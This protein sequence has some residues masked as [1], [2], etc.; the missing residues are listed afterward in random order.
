MVK[1][2]AGRDLLGMGVGSKEPCRDGQL[3][4]CYDEDGDTGAEKC[5]MWWI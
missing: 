1:G 4:E 3:A 2:F 5:V